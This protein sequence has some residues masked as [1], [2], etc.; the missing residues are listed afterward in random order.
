MAD[1]PKI[2]LLNKPGVTNWTEK[3]NA[4][5]GKTNWIRRTAEHLKGK[6]RPEHEAIP[7]AVKAAEK[8]CASGDT[9]FPGVQHVNAGSRAEACAAVTKWKAAAARA[10]A[11]DDLSGSEYFRAID[12]AGAR[13][14]RGLDLTERQRELI[15]LAANPFVK[16]SLGKTPIA[17]KSL[18]DVAATVRRLK[19]NPKMAGLSDQQ[20]RRVAA[21]RIMRRQLRNR[22]G[23]T[24]LKKLP[25]AQ[26]KALERGGLVGGRQPREGSTVNYTIQRGRRQGQT[27]TVR[28]TQSGWHEVAPK[29]EAK[30]SSSSHITEDDPRFNWRT[31][32]NG[33]RGVI[34]N[35]G[36]RKVVDGKTFDRLKRQGKLSKKT[37]KLKGD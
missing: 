25:R 23:I 26:V 18:Q 5:G 12:L 17:H 31:M 37:P 16:T 9:N 35:D 24:D 14:A 4:L 33:K 13:L 34:L 32:G 1:S 30:A 29:S 3:Y 11:A 7:I 6:G 19:R 20:L 2:A 27:V 36:T 15:D 10:K 28:F 21:L 22:L 8:L